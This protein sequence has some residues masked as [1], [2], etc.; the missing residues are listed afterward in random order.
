MACTSQDVA[1]LTPAQLVAYLQA[2]TIECLESFV[3]TLDGNLESVLSNA[4]V[5]A[6]LAEIVTR[7]SAYMGDDRQHLAELLT[8]ARAAYYLKWLNQSNPALFTVAAVNPLALVAVD[9]FGRNTHLLDF[10]PAAARILSAWVG[11]ADGADVAHFHI[12][13]FTSILTAFNGDSSR[14]AE[15]WQ[16]MSVYLV[17]AAVRRQ[18]DS[19]AAFRSQ[20][21]AGL[22]LQLSTLASNVNLPVEG[23]YLASNAVWALGGICAKAPAWKIPAVQMISSARAV[24]PPLSEPWLWTVD[25][26]DACNE[27]RD[28]NGNRFCRSEAALH[29]T[30][31]ELPHS[32][33]F[34][35]GALT[36]TTPLSLDGVQTLYHAVKTVEAQF[37][38]LTQTIAP[39]PGDTADRLTMVIFGSKA[40]YRKCGPF[41]YQI[42]VNNGGIYIEER[43]TL[44]TFQRAPAEEIY[45]LE[46]LVRH[47][48]AHYLVGRFLIAGMWNKTPIYMRDRMVWFDEGFAEFLTWSTLG[49][50]IR[51]R[52]RLVEL[53]SAD[54]PNRMKVSE[55]LGTGRGDFRFYRYSALLFSYWYENDMATLLEL[56]D[57]VR[58][59]NLEAYDLKIADLE[60]DAGLQAAYDHYLTT[61]IGNLNQLDDPVTTVPPLQALDLGTTAAVESRIRQTRLGYAADCSV[62]AVVINSRFSARGELVSQLTNRRSVTD[63]W[64]LFDANLDEMIGDLAQQGVSNFSAL[65]A[66]F[67]KIRWERIGAGWRAAADYFLEGPLAPAT[68]SLLPPVDQVAADFRSTRLGINV[69]TTRATPTRVN[70]SLSLVTRLYPDSVSRIELLDAL[71]AARDELRNQ[72]YTIRPSYYRNL[73]TA[74]I[75]SMQIIASANQQKYALRNALYSVEGV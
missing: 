58:T 49:S 52:R 39:L 26:L 6:V 44:Y 27:C 73:E 36:V 14:W 53:V 67:G 37:S 66:R 19:N 69:Q 33:S 3:W 24:W 9:A 8:F 40:A 22:L 34:D 20:L 16:Q 12:D 51:P 54:G 75:G 48:F 68:I 62:T 64:E 59:A 60:A 61:L 23:Q 63:A 57:L 72:V 7:S 11:L 35:D 2:S 56:I 31:F 55:V 18:V 13:R 10:N 25:A 45:P 50:G 65:T 71:E 70:A 43:A 32:Y 4:H 41:L 29:L 47:E 5:A 28:A 30:N 21:N 74:W 46:E 1:G 42:P 17:S 15:Y 38:R